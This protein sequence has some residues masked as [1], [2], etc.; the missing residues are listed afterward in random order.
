MHIAMHFPVHIAVL[1]AGLIGF[2]IW[3]NLRRRRS[4]STTPI[5]GVPCQ[6]KQRRV[7]HSNRVI[8]SIG[9]PCDERFEFSLRRERWT[10]R[11]AKTLHLVHEFQTGDAEFDAAVYIAADESGIGD[12]LAQDAEARKELLN[13]LAMPVYENTRVT[14]IAA[15]RGVLT[16][17]ALCNPPLFASAPADL[18]RTVATAR[19]PG[20]M[21]Q[22]DRLQASAGSNAD[23]AAF[24]DPYAAVVRTLRGLSTGLVVV[25][26]TLYLL[27]QLQSPPVAL[28]TDPFTDAYIYKTLAV[29]ILTMAILG[30]LLLRGSARLHTVLAR[31]LLL[32]TFG[33]AVMAPG[34]LNEVNS[35]FDRAIPHRYSSHVLYRYTTHGRNSTYYHVWLSD[36]HSHRDHQELAVNATTYNTLRE[37]NA[38]TVFEHPGY[39]RRP[40]ISDF[41]RDPAAPDLPSASV[42]VDRGNQL[43]DRGQYPAAIAAFDDALAVDPRNVTAFADRALAYIWSNDLQRG[44]KD[45]LAAAALDP[46]DRTV[47][48]G[49]GLLALRT[50]QFPSAVQAFTHALAVDPNDGFAFQ[51][52]AESYLYLGQSTQA[53]SDLTA[54]VRLLPQDTFLYWL[55]AYAAWEE[56]KT[57]EGLQQ[58]ESLI[59]TRPDDAGAHYLAGNIYALFAQRA[60]A[61]RAYDRSI[62][63]SPSE[64]AYLARA[65]NRPTADL[66]SRRADTAAAV[67][68]APRSAADLQRL[69]EL[70]SD[71][72]H[73]PDAISEFSSALQLKER[74]PPLLTRRAVAYAKAG[75]TILA[76]E[77][78]EQA[79]AL[80]Q[81]P[82]VLNDLCW[83]LATEDVELTRAMAAC[84]AAVAASKAPQN[85]HFLDS[86]GFVLLRLGRCKE[87]IDVYNQA[88]AIKPLLPTALYGRGICERR[89][90]DL[91][92]ARDDMKDGRVFSSNSVA[93]DF[94]RYGITR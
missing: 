34:L 85:V 93:A 35:E 51:M 33:T 16:L 57:P 41:R 12:W 62:E 90:G 19:V 87:A 65:A 40:W 11:M 21:T 66:A 47:L 94:A 73:Y 30:F 58:A 4:T 54:A 6:L 70:D 64:A 42:S 48:H 17:T 53:D 77:D 26:L 45:V 39:L 9:I 61:V 79:R 49:E 76:D 92:S 89:T 46:N 23:P 74:S 18:S 82:A 67:K 91:Q 7:S 88:L 84:R 27:L 22:R 2:S 43:M 37:G 38:V 83:T 75:Q 36:W 25:P 50:R 24:R 60:L 8:V 29:A 1:T 15:A 59:K 72:G 86:L 69:A 71:M 5:G 68:L 31:L 44:R 10:D 55:R 80:A 3:P 28:A 63:L 78:I 81:S 56:H 20:L 32:G 52:R 14:A 13:L